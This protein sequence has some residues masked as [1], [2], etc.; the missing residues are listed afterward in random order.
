MHKCITKIAQKKNL[1]KYF[2][3]KMESHDFSSHLKVRKKKEESKKS[4]TIKRSK[5]DF[6]YGSDFI[7]LISI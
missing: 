1:Q 2:I 5:K 3:L 6:Y 7:G 4:I